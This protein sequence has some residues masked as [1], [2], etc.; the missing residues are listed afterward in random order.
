M[1]ELFLSYAHEDVGSAETLAELLE[2]NGLNVWWDRRMVPG[3]RIHDVIVEQIEGAKAVIVLWSRTSVKS[4]WVRGEA[5]TAHELN[6]LV[7]IKIEECKLPI[8]YRGIHTPEVYKKNEL[9]KLAQILT[10]KFKTSHPTQGTAPKRTAEIKF[11]DKSVS[12][13][14]WRLQTQWARVDQEL[15][16]LEQ[17]NRD[18]GGKGW[19]IGI[20]PGTLRLIR[21]NPLGAAAL[22]GRLFVTIIVCV[23]VIL[24]WAVKL[25]T[26]WFLPVV[27]FIAIV[28]GIAAVCRRLWQSRSSAKK[29]TTATSVTIPY[30]HCHTLNRVPS[31]RREGEGARCGKCHQSLFPVHA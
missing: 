22:F 21:E 30:P 20:P 5:Q 24:L 16:R 29:T 12:N 13:F 18:K 10:D 1:A 31:E 27:G 2:A 25:N 14:S 8:N 17:E 7:P 9:S 23:L 26:P 3:D 28:A 15:G 4:D 11:T 19:V 6:K